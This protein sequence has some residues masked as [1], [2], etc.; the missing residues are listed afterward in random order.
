MVTVPHVSSGL[1]LRNFQA[2]G[3]LLTRVYIRCIAKRIRNSALRPQTYRDVRKTIWRSCLLQ[4]V[5]DNYVSLSG[6]DCWVECIRGDGH[7]ILRMYRNV[8]LM[9]LLPH[10]LTF[11]ARASC[12][13]A[14]W[15]PTAVLAA[16]VAL[17]SCWTAARAAA[18]HRRAA[19]APQ[20]LASR[21]HSCFLHLVSDE[22]WFSVVRSVTSF[23]LLKPNDIYICRTAALTSRRYILN[24]YSTNIRTEYFKHAA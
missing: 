12:G 20:Y 19:V 2:D 1:G 14:S 4:Q 24:I 21:E 16:N 7:E 9:T 5:R 13:P 10:P 11:A 15:R 6:F 8:R 3:F 22:W 17:E 18:L 23:N